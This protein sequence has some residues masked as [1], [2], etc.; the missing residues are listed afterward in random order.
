M[1]NCFK[2]SGTHSIGMLSSLDCNRTTILDI[3]SLPHCPAVQNTSMLCGTHIYHRL[4][5]SWSGVCTLVLLFPELGVIQENEPLRIP[6]VDMIAAQHKRAVQVMS[7]L[8]ATGI[9]IGAGTG[10]AGIASSMTQYNTFT[11]KFKSKFREMSETVLTIQKQIDSLAAVVLENRQGIDVLTAKEVPHSLCLILQEECCFYVNQSEI[12]RNK[13]QELQ[14]DI[15]NFRN[16]GPPVLGFL[17]TLYG[18]GYTV[19]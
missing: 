12:V 1:V 2:T 15:Q 16:V 13:I 4:P 9:A 5:T 7:L 10:I 6:V 17:K 3:S 19:L 8:V 18:S 11:S 14:S